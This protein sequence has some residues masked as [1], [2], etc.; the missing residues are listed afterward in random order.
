MRPAH[1]ISIEL[2]LQVDPDPIDTIHVPG[3][4]LRMCH[5]PGPWRPDVSYALNFSTG[6]NVA[7]TLIDLINIR[8]EFNLV[9]KCVCYLSV[10]KHKKQV[11]LKWLCHTSAQWNCGKEFAVMTHPAETQLGYAFSSTYKATLLL[12][13]LI[14][15][16][17]P[18][19]DHLK[20]LMSNIK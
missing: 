20:P 18:I 2:N 8:L 16:P 4:F 6:A 15:R 3:I 9:K 19:K 7:M 17:W 13:D 1:C 14:E 10:Y 12:S 11:K 5:I